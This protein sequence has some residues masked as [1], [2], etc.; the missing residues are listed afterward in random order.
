MLAVGKVAAALL[1]LGLLVTDFCYSQSW[2]RSK[3]GCR[4]STCHN[5]HHQLV[6]HQGIPLARYRS[7]QPGNAF[8]A[9]G[10]SRGTAKFSLQVLVPV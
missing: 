10:G 3:I 7:P 4:R 9:Q 1:G 6:P 8:L 2:T 5:Y